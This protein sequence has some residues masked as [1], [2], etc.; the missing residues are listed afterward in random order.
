MGGATDHRPTSQAPSGEYRTQK[1]TE[2]PSGILNKGNSG[3]HG[4]EAAAYEEFSTR[5]YDA[6]KPR[7]MTGL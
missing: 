1:E 6:D 2:P 5:V 7:F 3:Q 4:E